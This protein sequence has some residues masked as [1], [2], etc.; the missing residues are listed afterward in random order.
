MISSLTYNIQ[1]VQKTKGPRKKVLL[2]RLW[3]GIDSG[4]EGIK[5]V[6]KYKAV[7]P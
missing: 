4:L 2:K 5:R 7:S 6:A 3:T 1:M